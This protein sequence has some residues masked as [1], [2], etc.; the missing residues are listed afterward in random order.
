[1]QRYSPKPYEDGML[2]SKNTSSQ[3]R[4]RQDDEDNNDDDDDEEVRLSSPWRCHLI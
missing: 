3:K 2:R 1:M 4:H